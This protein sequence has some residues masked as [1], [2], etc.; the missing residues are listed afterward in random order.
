MKE[1][2]GGHNKLAPMQI[3]HSFSSLTQL[4]E[5]LNYGKW[6]ASLTK[7]PD[8]GLIFFFLIGGLGEGLKATNNFSFSLQETLKGAK[9]YENQRSS[10]WFLLPNKDLLINPWKQFQNHKNRPCNYS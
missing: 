9:R 6:L 3:T 4:L 5:S 1:M 10:H 2:P 8:K 7:I